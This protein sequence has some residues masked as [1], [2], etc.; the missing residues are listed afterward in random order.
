L[1]LT[2]TRPLVWVLFPHIFSLSNLL[3]FYPLTSLLGFNS[4]FTLKI[5]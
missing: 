2:C 1:A 5:S 4:L 3:Y